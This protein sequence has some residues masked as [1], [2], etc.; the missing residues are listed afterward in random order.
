MKLLCI[1]QAKMIKQEGE[2]CERYDK[3]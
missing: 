1:M 2:T 3:V